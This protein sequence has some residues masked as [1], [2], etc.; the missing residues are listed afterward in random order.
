LDSA[1]RSHPDLKV[2]AIMP[3][4]PY[5]SP[6]A[7]EVFASQSSSAVSAGVIQQLAGTKPWV[8]FI[9][10]LT[11]IGAGL[12]LILG[13]VMMLMGSVIANASK[14]PMF[15]GGMGVVVA[16]IYI[17]M[18]AYIYPGVKLWKYANYIGLLMSSGGVADLEM[19]LSQQRSFWK[20]V[21]I[22]LLV[23]VSLYA[24]IFV[25]AIVLGGFA[26]LNKG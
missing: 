21:G 7:N 13:L 22:I 26:A 1:C 15:T 18:A 6:A 10:V 25:G 19:A 2:F 8:R 20:F 11:F 14:N 9:S 12:M 3:I 4:D 24:L 17:V 5:A 16:V 23:F